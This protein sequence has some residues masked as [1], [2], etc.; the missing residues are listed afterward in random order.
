MKNRHTPCTECRKQRRKCIQIS[1]DQPC[2][3]CQK[4]DKICARPENCALDPNNEVECLNQEV[5]ELNQAI[6]RM[7]HELKTLGIKSPLY[8][9]NNTMTLPRSTIENLFYNWKIKI[10]NGYFTIDTGIKYISDLLPHYTSIE[11]LSPMTSYSSSSSE[12]SWSDGGSI[13]IRFKSQEYGGFYGLT[14]KML[15]KWIKKRMLGQQALLINHI[16]CGS[17]MLLDRLVD[18]YFNCHNLYCGWLHESSFRKRYSQLKEP[19]DDLICASLCCYVCA[20]PCDHLDFNAYQ[21]R[22]MCDYFYL[23]AKEKLV[24]QFDEPDKRLENVIAINMLFS[25]MHMTLKLIEYDT[26]VTMGYQICLDLRSEYEAAKIQTGID[27]ALFA[28]HFSVA[29]CL[30]ITLDCVVNKPITRQPIPFPVMN[31]LPDELEETKDFIRVM[32]WE[33]IH[34][35][36]IGSTC[37]ISFETVARMDQFL[38]DF[39]K[40]IPSEWRLCDNV[41]DEAKCRKALDQTTNPVA[42][43][44]FLHFAVLIVI[45]YVTILQ[46][47]SVNDENDLL[48]QHIQ[49][50]ALEKSLKMSRLL[51]YGVQRLFKL[52]TL[53]PCHVKLTSMIIMLYLV[54]PIVLQCSSPIKSSVLEAQKMF[55]KCLDI[56]CNIRGI[57]RED[58]PPQLLAEKK[59]IKDFIHNGSVDIDYYDRFPDPWCALLHDVSQFFI[60]QQTLYYY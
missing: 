10:N 1:P 8:I 6:Q 17:R 51:L 59:D 38:L 7:E 15:T 23:K 39:G 12:D 4:L 31:T 30:R 28:R 41:F 27:Y 53:S 48:L 13:L 5:N 37:T 52:K 21:R 11:Y 20:T 60:S 16:P 44:A 24:D 40:N 22:D 49:R 18:I 46:P 29:Y 55:Q 47:V 33:Q 34:L 25:Y 54:D 35:I 45:L 19:L 58:T 2:L 26:Y 50:N 9:K 3:R 57:Q 56:I 32:T 43:H 42:I 14:G 36:L